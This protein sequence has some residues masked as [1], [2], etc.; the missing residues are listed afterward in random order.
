MRISFYDKHGQHTVEIIISITFQN[1][2]GHTY[3]N[4]VYKP[5]IIIKNMEKCNLFEKS[6]LYYVIRH[7]KYRLTA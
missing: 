2:I 3:Q 5:I 6:T 1:V 7:K 4:F